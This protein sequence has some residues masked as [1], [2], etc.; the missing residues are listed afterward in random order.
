MT[1]HNPEAMVLQLDQAF[2]TGSGSTSHDVNRT[3]T[4]DFAGLTHLEEGSGDGLSAEHREYLL[5]RHGTTEVNRMPSM[6]PVDPLNWPSWKASPNYNDKTW[7][8]ALT[9]TRKR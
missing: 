1:D 5:K 8:P 3:V 6:D 9:R 7:N 4:K 2:G